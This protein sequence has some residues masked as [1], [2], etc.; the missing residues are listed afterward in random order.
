[1]LDLRFK[2]CTTDNMKESVNC[3]VVDQ[4]E[5]LQDLSTQLIE[6]FIESITAYQGLT[7]HY[8]LTCREKCLPSL[9]GMTMYA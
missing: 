5:T 7:V 3:G 9:P 8:V 6:V 2:L 4:F 1:M